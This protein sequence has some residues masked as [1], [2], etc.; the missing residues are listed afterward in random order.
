MLFSLL[1]A[2]TECKVQFLG[3]VEK[4]LGEIEKLTAVTAIIL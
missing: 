2:Y 1:D 3:L 4:V